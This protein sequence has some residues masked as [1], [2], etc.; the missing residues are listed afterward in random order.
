MKFFYLLLAILLICV[1]VMS[2]Q[3]WLA[4]LFVLVFTYFF[5]AVSLVVFAILLDGYFSS[6]SNVPVLSLLMLGWYLVSEL[7]R[8]RMRII[9]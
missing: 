3:L 7:A 1:A 8:V 5:G 9:K 6:F 2:N 4:A